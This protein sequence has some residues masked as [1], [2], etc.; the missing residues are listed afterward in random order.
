MSKFGGGG[1]KCNVC[2]KT[3]YPAEL[4]QFEKIPF[5]I[6]CFR[7]QEDRCGNKIGNPAGA[8]L[9]KIEHDD[10]TEEKKIYCKM[11][12][13]AGGYAQKQKS[14]KWV[15]KDPACN[16]FASKFGGGGNPCF[17]C[18]KTVYPAE[19][20][21]YEKKYFHESCFKCSQC[22]KKVT[23]SSAALY[24]DKL[25]CT[26][27][28]KAGGY[29]S[30]QVKQASGSTTSTKANSI[31]SKFGGGGN[32]CTK[33]G[34]T[35]Y[36]AEQITYE[37]QV[38]HQSCFCCEKCEKKI[39]PANASQFE[40][41]IYCKKCFAE[42]GYTKKQAQ[43]HG[44]STTTASKPVSNRFAKFGGGGMKCKI[45]DKTV[46]AAENVPYEGF[47]YHPKCFACKECGTQLKVNAAEFNKKTETLWCK[48]CFVQQKFD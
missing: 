7:C 33:C 27:C 41:K 1:V 17:L 34:K 22:E 10:G 24:E 11:C 26:N 28:F 42:G 48:K 36:M 31:A 30:Q 46:Y 14:V 45:C 6:N 19:T 25:F 3:A 4:V 39:T 2:V 18:K 44:T 40:S 43:S 20:V 12:F 29:T 16:N 47:N 32:P 38:F 13:S 21:Q 9:F 37:K 8:M 15:K 5:H 35:V 23:P